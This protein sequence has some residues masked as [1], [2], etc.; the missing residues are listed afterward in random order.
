M[1]GAEFFKRFKKTNQ[2]TPFIFITGYELTSEIKNIVQDADAVINKP[3]DF[4]EFLEL[5][6]N[7]HFSRN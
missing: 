2:N 1:N 6:E 7:L 3:I 5:I 4:A